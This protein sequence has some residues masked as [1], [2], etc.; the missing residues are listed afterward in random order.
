MEFLQQNLLLVALCASSGLMFLWSF[1]QA[2]AANNVGAAEATRLINNDAVVVD[3][4]EPGEF[5][6]G[7][8]AGARNIPLGKLGDRSNELEKFKGQPL[9]VCCAAGGR[10][11]RACQQLKKLGF[12]NLHNLAGGM[13]AWL[14]AGLPV[15]KGS[16]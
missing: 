5:S 4:R 1:F 7:H 16:K 3:V 15:K 9:V 2:S 10:S 6:V 11:S 14:Q 8:I 12:E 13:D